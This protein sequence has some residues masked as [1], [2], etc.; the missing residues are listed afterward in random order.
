VPPVNYRLER[1]VEQRAGSRARATWLK[2]VNPGAADTPLPPCLL[3]EDWDE[4]EERQLCESYLNRLSPRL[5]MLPSLPTETRC[6][7]EVAACKH[8]FEVERFHAVYPEVVNE[9]LLKAA[10]VEARLRRSNA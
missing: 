7:L 10:R 5:L 9:G 1:A 6:R 3:R 4:A 2:R 8:A